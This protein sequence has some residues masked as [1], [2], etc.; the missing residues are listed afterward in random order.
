M[1]MTFHRGLS[2]DTTNL[3]HHTHHQD[4]DHVVGESNH[5]SPS[6]TATTPSSSTSKRASERFRA[7]ATPTFDNRRSRES[8]AQLS[9]SPSKA[10]SEQNPS[11]RDTNV[12]VC[13]RLR[14]ILPSDHQRVQSQ[15]Q[16]QSQH[17][18][19]LRTSPTSTNR[20]KSNSR[21]PSGISQQSY[22]SSSFYDPFDVVD[23]EPAW[24]IQDN[25][26]S[27]SEHT[28]PESNRRNVYTFDHS[29]GPDHTTFDIYNDTVKD[30]VVSAMEGYH[31]SV[32]AY[33]QTATGKTF[34]MS[35]NPK[36]NDDNSRGII[37]LAIQDCFDFIYDQKDE[38]R[39]YLLRVSFMEIYNEA[40]VDL[41]AP[42][43]TQKPMMVNA[44]SSNVRQIPPAPS[45]IRIFES[46]NEGVQIR[47]LK[48][49]IVTSPED[50][51]ALLALGER[52]R[53]T[54]C[55]S[56]NRK[57]SRSHSI[58]RLIIESR[59]RFS[60]RSDSSG[61]LRGDSSVADSLASNMF[62][63]SN[64]TG[65]VR[66]STLSLVDLAGSES[67]RNTGSTGVRQKEGQYINKSLLTL[68]HV[69]Y[70]LA[71]VS[72]KNEDGKSGT[73]NLHIP[74]RDSKLT[75]I[76]QPSLSGNAQVV[77][78]CNISPLSKHVDESHL[79]L[80]F[81][82]RAKRIKQHATITEV[83]DEK[84]MLEN[85]REEI[86]D[87]KAQ[88]EEAKRVQETLLNNS[89]RS[90]LPMDDDDAEVLTDAITNLE[91]LILKTS[92]HA[93]KKRRKKRRER[94]K[95]L[96]KSRG[97][98]IKIIGSKKERISGDDDNDTL[99][100][101]MN[102]EKTLEE[103][104][105]LG[106]LS[107]QSKLRDD[108]SVSN[109]SLE[110]D[111]TIA[112]K[113]KLV[114]ELHRIQGSLHNILSKNGLSPSKTSSPI[115]RIS[116][117]ND[118]EVE[119]LRA[120]LHDQAVSTSLRQADSTFLESQLQEKDSLLTDISQVLEEV[121]KRQTQLEKDNERLRI[122]WAKSEEFIR[123]KESESLIMEKL[124]KKRETEIK[125]LKKELA[126]FGKKGGQ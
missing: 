106:E 84:T 122:E 16:S 76:L 123:A 66:V 25:R 50:V 113:N 36:S 85:Y 91:R 30:A 53:Q 11:E 107:Y 89:N 7:V 31:S 63:P 27:Q 44:S 46:K 109:G 112:E 55:T 100:N 115:K 68:G 73:D 35:G 90:S 47:G 97:V 38:T 80:K 34:T 52:R 78:I 26:I 83:I 43:V 102:E 60:Q 1:T 21:Q 120:Q 10:A 3:N 69:I 6:S 86:E 45:T 125:K 40:I 70:K 119:R 81:A 2:I 15:Q 114:K 62:A 103:D 88:L 24:N 61:D 5:M 56:M 42:Q 99:L 29:F 110:D 59:K 14:P 13:V 48:E 4:H 18:A 9:R 94:M 108:H 33:G 64:T 32:F 116:S 111:S 49:E 65:P 22:S 37:P 79:T 105:L 104:D 77:I 98:P 19:S 39:E 95:A 118:E 20:F 23:M 121:E 124:L 87:L 82:S 93:E 75:R 117:Q 51:F 17:S 92:S 8:F 101:A 12:Q 54:G 71:E 72:L 28:N 96:E 57:S 58:F 41:L 67:I 74:Y 126:A